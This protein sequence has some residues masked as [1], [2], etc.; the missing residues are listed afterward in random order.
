MA[1]PKTCAIEALD[2]CLTASVLKDALRAFPERASDTFL[3][4]INSI[5]RSLSQRIDAL[6]ECGLDINE[7]HLASSRLQLEIQLRDLSPTDPETRKNAPMLSLAVSD[8]EWSLRTFQKAHQAPPV[9]EQLP[10]P[11]RGGVRR[12][13]LRGCPAGG[14]RPA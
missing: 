13:F 2:F 1:D 8:I 5:Y 7:S 3:G 4:E 9:G 6:G 12:A 11:T 10:R 14:I